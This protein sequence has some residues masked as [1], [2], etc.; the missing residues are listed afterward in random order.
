MAAMSRTLSIMLMLA[1]KKGIAIPFQGNELSAAR[2]YR[3][4]WDSNFGRHCRSRAR[5]YSECISDDRVV[6]MES[7]AKFGRETHS[8][9]VLVRQYINHKKSEK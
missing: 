8:K 2:Y 1:I 3:I 4:N 7:G 6:A 9:A 5:T